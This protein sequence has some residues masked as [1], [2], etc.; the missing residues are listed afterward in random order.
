MY[1]DGISYTVQDLCAPSMPFQEACLQMKRQGIAHQVKHIHLLVVLWRKKNRQ[2]KVCD[3]N[4]LSITPI[5]FI[6]E[7]VSHGNYKPI[8]S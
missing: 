3:V 1:S 5:G 6:Y 4:N 8:L 7:E 2:Q